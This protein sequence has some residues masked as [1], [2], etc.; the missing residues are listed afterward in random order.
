MNWVLVLVLSVVSVVVG[1]SLNSRAS[2]FLQKTRNRG[3]SSI[4]YDLVHQKPNAVGSN[5]NWWF[6]AKIY[7][8]RFFLF[9]GL[10]LFIGGIFC[11]LLSILK[12]IL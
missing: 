12:L 10:G 4:A 9:A 11:F 3:L 5:L 2:R 6:K 8:G 1:Y 7:A